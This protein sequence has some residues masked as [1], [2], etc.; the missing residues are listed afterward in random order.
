LI[1]SRC[2]EI[3]TNPGDVILDPFGG[4]GSSYEAAQRLG[5]Y[6]LGTEIV[7]AAPIRER[8][9]RAFPKLKPRIPRVLRKAFIKPTADLSLV[10]P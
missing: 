1:P 4:G 10:I 7:S 5:R 2:I 8:F 3:S 9:G 6:W